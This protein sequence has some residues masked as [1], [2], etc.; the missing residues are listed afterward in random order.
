MS[1][2]SNKSNQ[3][4][5]SSNQSN[6]SVE[7][8]LLKPQISGQQ[9]KVLV[10]K[11]LEKWF[12]SATIEYGMA[13][14]C[15]ENGVKYRP[16]KPSNM[17]IPPGATRDE[18]AS[19]KS[20]HSALISDWIKRCSDQDQVLP[21]IFGMG[22]DRISQESREI[23]EAY[24]PPLLD[25]NGSIQRDASGN[26]ITDPNDW[27]NANRTGTWDC[28][29][30]IRLAQRCKATHS[31][32][33]THIPILDLHNAK[34][35]YEE[36]KQEAN[37]SL[38]AFKTRFVERRDGVKTAG[39]AIEPPA[40]QA[41]RFLDA[42][43]S[44][45]A[46][47]F[48]DIQNQVRETMRVLPPDVHEAWQSAE[49]YVEVPSAG[50]STGSA[51]AISN[52]PASEKSGKGKKK[53]KG[54][55][56]GKPSQSSGEGQGKASES[57]SSG[58]AK[59]NPPTTPC[60]YCLGKYGDKRYHWHHDCELY[61]EAST[62]FPKSKAKSGST[63]LVF[64][65]GAVDRDGTVLWTRQ[66]GEAIP[67][68][69][70]SDGVC[71]GH[72]ALKLGDGLGNTVV[73]FDNQSTTNIFGNQSLLRNLRKAVFP[74]RITGISKDGESVYSDQV[75]DWRDFRGIYYSDQAAA[76]VLQFGDESHGCVN[77]FIKSE[78]TFV[79]QFPHFTYR[80]P[81]N[82]YGTY[83]LDTVDLPPFEE[84]QVLVGTVAENLQ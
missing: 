83:V 56:K 8:P 51:L 54:K 64:S 43:N 61:K 4:S 59:G 68:Q 77:D 10:S 1:G 73:A 69:P 62:D 58:S 35:L 6:L 60:R 15:I 7:I 50:A 78:D 67:L 11:W 17:V 9:P 19:I 21:K 55:G 63:H 44:K 23:I 81:R 45:Y 75:G 30:P 72:V 22:W 27:E 12:E 65:T 38:L 24:Q 2:N 42:L 31:A 20:E 26:I 47:F 80:F 34:R 14:K 13:A 49:H 5:Q 79:A 46:K 76:N 66:V 84:R 28:M 33:N 37:E 29:D 32:A 74:I 52:A 57:K 48:V 41:V 3:K 71:Q 18:K 39:G 82:E 36:C 53:G 16:I 70:G 40:E 25:A